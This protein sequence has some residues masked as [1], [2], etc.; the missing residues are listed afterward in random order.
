[1]PSLPD[2]SMHFFLQMAVILL[3][4][5]LVWLL[6]RRLGQ[7]QVVAVMATGFL[8]GPSVLGAVSP[9]AQDWLFPATIQIGGAAV[10]HPSLAVIYVVGQLGL[11][12]YMFLVGAAFETD[13]FTAHFRVARATAAAGVV[14]PMLLGGVTG[15]VLATRGGYFTDK[16]GSW[17]AALFL[18]AAIAITAFP[19][20][21]WIIH[22]SGLHHTRLGTMALACAASDDALSWLLLATVVATTKDS[23]NGA[24]VALVGGGGF[25]LFMFLIGRRLLRALNGW[26]D[27]QM[28]GAD[29]PTLPIA[30]FI[31]ILLVVLLSAW[32]TDLVGVYAVFGAFVAGVVLPRGQLL[33]QVRARTEPLVSHLLLPAFFVYS[34]LNT[35]LGLI[36]APSAMIVATGVLVISFGAKFGAVTLAGRYQG[37]SWREAGS[38]GSLANARG[39]TEL[40]LLNIGLAEGLITPTLYTILAL[41]AFVTTCAATPIFRLFERSA[42]KNGLVFGADGETPFLPSDPAASPH[43]VRMHG[44]VLR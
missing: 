40:I 2:L 24:V 34:G 1:M 35:Q 37:M 6:F 17:Q 30:P 14:V 18:A 32:F 38:M 9:A 4:S 26:A 42:W 13:I 12:L 3:A 19:I 33:E 39:L 21:A 22:D 15:A 41:M 7:V 20:L 11:V 25:V 28:R 27:R 23:M 5:R 16:I 8:L 10:P 31:A 44:R 36:L 43:R 29:G